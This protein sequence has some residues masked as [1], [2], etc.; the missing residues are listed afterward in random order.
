M[1]IVSLRYH[2]QKENIKVDYLHIY[3][4]FMKK[5]VNLVGQVLEFEKYMALLVYSY[6]TTVKAYCCCCS[7]ENQ[8]NTGS[9]MLLGC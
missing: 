3:L 7:P 4:E 5:T 9:Q 6:G 1:K 2:H 8:R